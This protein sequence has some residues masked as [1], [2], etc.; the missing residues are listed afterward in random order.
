MASAYAKTVRMMVNDT[1]R[2]CADYYGDGQDGRNW[3]WSEA[4]AA[5][6][7]A[8][9]NMT[10]ETEVLKESSLVPLTENV[11]VYDLPPNCLRIL[12][13]GIHGLAGRVVLPR[14]MAEY[15]Y[16][17][18]NTSATGFP[19]EFFRDILSPNQIGVYPTPSQTGGDFTRDS[20]YGLLRQLTDADGARIPFDGNR[21]LRRLAGV[22]FTRT[23]SGNIIREIIAPYGNLFLTY[24]RT[25]EF[26]TNPD[27]FIDS[28]IPEYVHKDI[29]Y[30]AALLLLPQ[31]STTVTA[32]KVKK[33]AYKWKDAKF[34]LMTR[35]RHKGPND[36]LRPA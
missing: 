28:G 16:Q 17:Q 11:A 29:R 35:S 14:A 10:R 19:Y 22:P 9:F 12:R 20:D 33:F 13:V 31:Q 27:H 1:L 2:L 6:K 25:P 26:P 4:Q 21:A 8:V 34:R 30:G 15:D 5:V 36:S 7:D 3:M 23:G 18:K 32:M 24:V